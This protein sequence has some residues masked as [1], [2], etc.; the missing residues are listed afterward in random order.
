MARDPKT[1]FFDVLGHPLLAYA[2]TNY[3]GG[4]ISTRASNSHA[5]ENLPLKIRIK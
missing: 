1:A 5:I 3:A 2:V 4:Y